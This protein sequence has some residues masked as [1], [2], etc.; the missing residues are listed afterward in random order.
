VESGRE[1]THYMKRNSLFLRVARRNNF[2]LALS[3][4]GKVPELYE[5]YNIRGTFEISKS[6]F[7]RSGTGNNVIVYKKQC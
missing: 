6:Y 2:G 3:A 7:I 5:V 4:P 1:Q